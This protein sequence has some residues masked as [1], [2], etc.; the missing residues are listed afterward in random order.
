[1]TS[2]VSA[3]VRRYRKPHAVVVQR[4]SDMLCRT[5]GKTAG[6]GKS[7]LWL[8]LPISDRDEFVTWALNDP[9]F[10]ARFAEW[11]ESG[12]QRAFA[13]TAHRIDRR[14]AAEGGA[15]YVTTNIEWRNH[16]EKSREALAKGVE[17]KKR[18]RLT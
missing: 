18:K 1:M 7:K 9:G 16:A 10:Q 3:R 12:Y 6:D 8:G 14:D 11:E 2:E 15:G 5:K 17:T 4:Y 13:P